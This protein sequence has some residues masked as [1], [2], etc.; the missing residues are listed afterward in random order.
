MNE[1]PP[2]VPFGAL[3]GSWQDFIDGLYGIYLKTLVRADL[4]F[5]GRPIKCQFRPE[6][7]GKGYGFWHMMQ[8]GK[9]EDERTID[10]E[11]CRRLLWIGWVISHADRDP[12]IRV[13]PQGKRGSEKPW[14]LWLSQHNY[15]VI[16][17]ERNGY[18]L[19]RTAFMV[20]GHKSKELDRDWQKQCQKD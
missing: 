3:D 12:Q 16:L 10:P 14:A 15:V 7:F 9:I 2:L 11:R 20:K 4:T 13:F 6:T 1:P 5:R 17:W 18:Y 19:L 8:E